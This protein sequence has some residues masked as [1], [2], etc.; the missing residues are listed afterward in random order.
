MRHKPLE[1]GATP[2]IIKKMI[3]LF[4]KK[5]V[6]SIKTVQFI[7]SVRA[8]AKQ[9]V[10]NSLSNKLNNYLTRL[11]PKD[12]SNNSEHRIEHLKEIY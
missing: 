1:N 10:I 7:K 8:L 3:N 12:K 5:G 4:E 6:K 9:V 11:H 2:Q